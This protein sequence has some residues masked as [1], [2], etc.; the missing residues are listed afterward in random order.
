MVITKKFKFELAHRLV[1]SYSKKCQSFHGHSYTAE[2]TLEGTSLDDTGML[3]DFG[4]V[5]DKFAHVIDGW[6]H[7][8]MLWK[9]DPTH[10]RMLD[11]S[12]EINGRFISVNYNPTAENM[13]YH[14]YQIL[15]DAGLPIKQVLVRETLT[16]WAIADDRGQAELTAHYTNIEEMN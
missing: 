16:G 3:M 1:D 13:A 9:A 6:D 2:V 10:D 7:S 14:M 15:W 5:K 4:E 11:I 8:L 12:N